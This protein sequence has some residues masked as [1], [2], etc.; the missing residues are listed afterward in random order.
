MAKWGQAW[1]GLRTILAEQV[2][3]PAGNDDDDDDVDD[4]DDLD[5]D[6]QVLSTLSPLHHQCSS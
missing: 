5:D 6:F 2:C 4:D 1:D 3:S